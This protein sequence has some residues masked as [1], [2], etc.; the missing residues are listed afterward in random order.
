MTIDMDN[1]TSSTT[2]NTV[3]PTKDANAELR[4]YA[5]RMKEERDGMYRELLEYR[6]EHVGL[7]PNE[8][9]GKAVAKEY[10]GDVN[11][12]AV[13]SYLASEYNYTPPTP[14]VP[15]EVVTEATQRVDEVMGQSASVT[16]EQEPDPVRQ[17]DQKMA[18]PEA[19]P[20]DAAQSIQAKLDAFNA[21][22]R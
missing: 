10:D 17:A 1:T 8:G 13:T 6:L 20:Q 15:E 22:N 3:E 2:S 11:L 5:D 21:I 7:N 16:P 19:T 14:S 18:D 12:D 4:A 9:L